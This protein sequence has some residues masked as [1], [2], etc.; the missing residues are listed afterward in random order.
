MSCSW[1]SFPADIVNAPT[2]AW[3]R[4]TGRK[5]ST[6]NCQPVS[7]TSISCKVVESVMRESVMNHLPRTGVLSDAQHGFVPKRSCLSYLLLIEQWVTRF[8]DARGCLWSSSIVHR[9]GLL[10]SRIV[11]SGLGYKMLSAFP[12]VQA[13]VFPEDQSSG[14][15]LYYS[16]TTCQICCKAASFCLSPMTSKLSPLVPFTTIRS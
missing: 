6:R 11:P 3:Q 13:V 2:P 4:I 9:V 14:L 10:S 15:F 12:S 7:L 1:N 8:M 16:S 5:A